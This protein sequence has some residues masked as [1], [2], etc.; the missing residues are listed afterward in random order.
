MSIILKNAFITELKT[1]KTGNVLTVT[2][3][4]GKGIV[5]GS[6]VANSGFTNT[7]EFYY[8]AGNVASYARSGTTLTN[9][10]TLGNVTGTLGTMTGVAY[11]SGIASGVF[12]FDGVSDRIQFGQYNFGNTITINAWVY[13]RSEYSINNLM[14][15]CV[16]NTNT[17]GFKASWNNW[18]STNYTLNFEAGNG[19]TGGTQ[20]TATNVVVAS[21]WQMISFVFD[22]TNHT[23]K[24]YKNGVEQATSGTPVTGIGMNNANWWMGAIGGS[25]YQMNA[26]MGEFRIYKSLRSSSELL[27]EYNATKTRYGL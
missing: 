23:I 13:P 17:L 5:S 20:S 1:S 9:I 19:T 2:D 15:N 3:F 7:A 10:G 4:V 25:S 24:F 21:T 22:N 16:A 11:E 18:N 27:S 14:S 12:N 8:D 6:V 26:N